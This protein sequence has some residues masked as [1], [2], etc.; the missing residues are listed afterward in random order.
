MSKK[1]T[2]EEY[3]SEIRKYSRASPFVEVNIAEISKPGKYKITGS[4]VSFEGKTLVVSDETEEITVDI[5]ELANQDFKEGMQ[6]QILGFAE[7]EPEKKLKAFIIQDFSEV[8]IELY[9]QVRELE[10]SLRKNSP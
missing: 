5:T 3:E 4:V 2:S 9:R 6:L 1:E 7:F 8:N 10:Q